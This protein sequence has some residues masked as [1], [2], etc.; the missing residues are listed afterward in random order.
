MKN[1]NLP[2][3]LVLGACL[4]QTGLLSAQVQA[5]T[6]ELTTLPTEFEYSV[7]FICGRPESD[8]P[9]SNLAVPGPYRTSIN[10]HNPSFRE[11]ARFRQKI[12]LTPAPGRVPGRITGFE[13]ATLRPDQALAITCQN[14][15][16]QLV[17]Q[18]PAPPFVEGFAVILSN[19]ELDVV[20]VYTA[21]TATVTTL[22]TERVPAR[23]ARPCGKLSL[24]LSTGA[25][26]P[27]K[28]T[29][30]EGPFVT[31]PIQAVDVQP[32]PGA[33]SPLPGASWISR[34]ASGSSSNGNVEMP[35]TYKYRTCF[36][37]CSGFTDAKLSLK[38]FA[39]NGVKVF[40]NNSSTPIATKIDPLD[41]G[42][43]GTPGISIPAAASYLLP[44]ENCLTAEVIDKGGSTGL[45][46]SGQL[47]A[48]AAACTP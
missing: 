35:G 43:T 44:G 39:D 21:G 36:C 24:D 45:I 15:I 16:G 23:L 48:E 29:L 18:P 22:H 14:I 10:I 7:K 3:T 38:V 9:P 34:I 17:D 27:A 4:L 32:V 20:A 2:R 5:Q 11:N 12:A 1:T 41:K 8:Q 33:W 37:I 13:R 26:N 25:S 42:F 31:A 46:L 6:N 47:E 40:L 28:W 30:L 19:I